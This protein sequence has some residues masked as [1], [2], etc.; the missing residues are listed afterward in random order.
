MVYKNLIY[1]ARPTFQSNKE[2]LDA[3]DYISKK[4]S[5]TTFCNSSCPSSK[6]VGTSYQNLYNIRTSTRIKK[7]ENI[8]TFNNSDLNLNLFTKMNLEG[9]T[10]INSN[11]VIDPSGVLFGNTECGI[12]NFENFL[13]PYLCP[14]SKF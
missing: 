6:L 1:P 5:T 12:N 14:V 2:S 4:I 7:Q 3:G 11:N 9:I 13:I 8:P 10:V